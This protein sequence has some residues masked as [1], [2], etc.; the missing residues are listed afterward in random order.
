MIEEFSRVIV[1]DSLGECLVIRDREEVWNFPGGKRELNETAETCAIREVEEELNLKIQDLEEIYSGSFR[2]DNVE[3]L[4]HFYFAATA[5]GRPTLNE[6]GKIKGIQFIKNLDSVQFSPQLKK[7]LNYL[8]SHR[9]LDSRETI[10]GCVA[11]F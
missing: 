11:K 9:V 6:P 3:W 8:T 7:L 2:F 1:K 10:W 4:G 5:S